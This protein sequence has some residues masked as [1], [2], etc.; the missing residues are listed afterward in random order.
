[1]VYPYTAMNERYTVKQIATL[2]SVS[3][4]T[5]H[6]YDEIGLLKPAAIGGNGY[7]YYNDASLLRLQQILLYRDMD[8]E[9]AQI[10]RILDDPGFDLVHALQSHRQTIQTKIE[11]LNTLMQTLDAT[12]MHVVGEVTMS[13]KRIFQGFD[14]E[15]Q[16]QYEVEAIDQYGETVKESVA[17]WNSY[18]E[19]KQ[20]EIL[21][22]GD[23]IYNAIAAAMATGPSSEAV[24]SLLVRWHA[25]IRYFYEPSIDTLAGLGDMY[26]D[27]PDFNA[28]FTKIDPAL[29][30]FLKQAIAVYVDTLETRW[31]EQ[32]L[33]IL[34]E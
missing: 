29:P 9:L 13:E 3:V 14:K 4:R 2:A 6:Y 7:R 34:E 25:H 32:E 16:K 5:L 8:I 21:A 20:Q 11:Q 33:G 15:K 1:M 17:L 18:G 27:H 19:E 22:E 12:I 28:T 24:Q 26:Y 31:L 30:G 10:K 23:A